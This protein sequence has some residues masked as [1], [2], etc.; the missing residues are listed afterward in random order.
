[1]KRIEILGPGCQ[2]CDALYER[3]R[4]AVR[5]LGLECTIDKVSDIEAIVRRGVLSTPALV[6][7]GEVKASG[8][9]PT[10]SEIRSLLS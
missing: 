6:L 5:E 10:A 7:D 4:E 8:R 9:V 2:K 1:M 3:T